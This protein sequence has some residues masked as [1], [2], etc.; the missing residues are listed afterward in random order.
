MPH[1][2]CGLFP[3][4]RH[5]LYEDRAARAAA[6]HEHIAAHRDDALEHVAQVA[7]DGDLLHWKLDLAAVDPVAG[8]A[9]RIVAGDEIDALSEQFRHEKTTAHLAQHAGKVGSIG[10]QHEIVMPAGV[11]GGLHAEL[12]RGIAAEE[13]AFEHAIAHHAALAR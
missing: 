13:I 1:G 10:A 6:A 9:A 3:G 5:V 8:G 7:G 11:A 12:A 4:D 2:P